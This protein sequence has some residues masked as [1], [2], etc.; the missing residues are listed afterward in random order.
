MNLRIIMA[1]ISTL[2]L[3][4]CLDMDNRSQEPIT[5]KFVETTYSG[6]T[7][8]KLK[9]V[10]YRIIYQLHKEIGPASSYVVEFE[11]PQNNGA[12]FMVKAPIKS[13]ENSLKI[14]SPELPGI[15][16]KKSYNVT[17]HL[18][19]EGKTI[20][21]HRDQ[22]RFDMPEPMLKRLKINFY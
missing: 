8:E 22:V 17:L 10:K 20:A 11:N 12:S 7:V 13:G 3:T 15:S 16:L 9:F 4:A 14:E 18:L 2:A 5:S 6:F 19:S 1:S 21:I